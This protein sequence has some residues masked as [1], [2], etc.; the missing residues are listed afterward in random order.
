MARIEAKMNGNTETLGAHSRCRPRH[1]AASVKLLLTLGLFSA[2]SLLAANKLSA[3]L[4]GLSPADSVDVIVQFTRPP[5]EADLKAVDHAG[6][7]LKHSFQRIHGGLFTLK[8][9]QLHAMAANPNIAYVSP[10]RRVSGSLEFAEPTVNANIA[11][12]YGWTGAGVG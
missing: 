5:S 12:Q 10:D 7:V 1:V 2:S 8:A 11:L 4:E 9:G 3:E 6:G